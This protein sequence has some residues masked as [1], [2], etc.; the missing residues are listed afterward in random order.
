MCRQEKSPAFFIKLCKS[1][2]Y[3]TTSSHFEQSFYTSN[4][5][6]AVVGITYMAR[7]DSGKEDVLIPDLNNEI[8]CFENV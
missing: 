7:R 5:T 2:P 4:C 8:R 1:G 3:S 6:V